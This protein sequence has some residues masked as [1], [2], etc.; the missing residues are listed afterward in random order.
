MNTKF[1]Q[2]MFTGLPPPYC[3]IFLFVKPRS[4]D[5]LTTT[6]ILITNMRQRYLD[7]KFALSTL[8]D[9]YGNH[10]DKTREATSSLRFRAARAYARAAHHLPLPRHGDESSGS[11]LIALSQADGAS[12][13]AGTHTNISALQLHSTASPAQ[14]APG[15]EDS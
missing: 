8:P 7:N 2:Y 4:T 15:R 11:G 3:S 5:F 1:V 10:Y 14:S 13:P 9:L 6:R 12:P